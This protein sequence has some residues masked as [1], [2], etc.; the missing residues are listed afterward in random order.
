MTHKAAS[1][2]PK[3]TFFNAFFAQNIVLVQA[4]NLCPILAAGTTLQKGLTL[5]VCTALVLLPISLAMSLVGEKIPAWV[6]PL[7]YTTTAGLLM[8][9]AS[10]LV[11]TYIS[12][13]LYASLY[14][15]L[16]L[17][18]VSTVLTYRAGGFSVRQNAVTALLDSLGS[19]LGFG[20]VICLVGAVR[21][22]AAYGTIWNLPVHPDVTIPEASE[23]FVA[24]LLLAFM[25]A[26]LQ[27][28]KNVR[29]RHAK[30]REGGVTNG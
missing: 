22:I 24:F 7:V 25:A 17:T 16:P 8:A 29:A 20:L 10:F 9:G 1:T 30:A 2:Y 13:E 23:P 21:E 19:S 15:F 3:G 11:K 26:L 5:A 27:W 4:L 28:I 6:R 12:E 18:A 14:V